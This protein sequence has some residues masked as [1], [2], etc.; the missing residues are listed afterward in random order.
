LVLLVL[1][2]LVKQDGEWP[3]QE[4]EEGPQA[5]RAAAKQEAI[6]SLATAMLQILDNQFNEP[7]QTDRP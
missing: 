2:V 5:T 1:K 3:Y 7:L 4:C 6:K